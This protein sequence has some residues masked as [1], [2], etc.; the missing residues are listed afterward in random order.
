MIKKWTFIVFQLI[1]AVLSVLLSVGLLSA[2]VSTSNYSADMIEGVIEDLISTSGTPD[3]EIIGQGSYI[4]KSGFRDPLLGGSS[5][6][7]MR[8][9]LKNANV[10]PEEAARRWVDVQNRIR[11]TVQNKFG[12]MTFIVNGKPVNA[13]QAILQKI[14][15]YPPQQMMKGVASKAEAFALFKKYGVVPN[16]GYGAGSVTDDILEEAAEGIWGSGAVIQEMEKGARGK[17]WFTDGTTNKDGTK[18]VLTG[19]PGEIHAEEGIGGITAQERANVAKQVA[20]K[21]SNALGSDPD[22]V[23]KNLTRLQRYL[24]QAKILAGVKPSANDAM[25][26]SLVK[27]LEKLEG[28]ALEK[29]IA[30]KAGAIERALLDAWTDSHLLEQI[31]TKPGALNRALYG[32]MLESSG[33]W[34]SVRGLLNDAE[35]KA[36]AKRQAFMAAIVLVWEAPE[37]Y[38]KASKEGLTSAA[39]YAT[40]TLIA[41][42]MP[43]A[44]HLI[45][46]AAM[47]IA[48]QMVDYVAGYGYD[49]I[50]QTQDCRDLLAGLY[51]V[52]G[53]EAQVLKENLPRPSTEVQDLRAYYCQNA[54]FSDAQMSANLSTLVQAHAENACTR[55]EDYKASTDANAAVALFNKC[56]PMLQRLLMLEKQS[57]AYEARSL[58]QQLKGLEV[59]PY[60]DKSEA[61]L[62]KGK[63]TVRV[64]APFTTDPGT[65]ETDLTAIL[66]C[67]DRGDKNPGVYYSYK[68][69]AGPAQAGDKPLETTNGKRNARSY[70]FDKAGTQKVCVALETSITGISSELFLELDD[71]SV[72]RNPVCIDVEIREGGDELPGDKDDSKDDKTGDDKPGVGDQKDGK[73]GDGK[74]GDGDKKE[75]AADDKKDGQKSSPQVQPD[76]YTKPWEQAGIQGG[77]SGQAG[78][79]SGVS[80]QAG[81]TQQDPT[82]TTQT[83]GTATGGTQGTTGTTGVST[84][85]GTGKDTPVGSQTGI[86]SGVGAGIGIDKGTG[87]TVTT[88]PKEP[89]VCTYE[90][91]AW[92]ECSRATKTRTRTVT[93][94]K[95]AGCVEKGKPVLEEGCQP[96]PTEEEKRIAY[97]N[98]LCGACGGTGGGYYNP[99]GWGKPCSCFGMLNAWPTGLNTDPK[100]VADC[101]K[102]VYGKP[103]TPGD[104]DKAVKG[105]KNENRK[106]QTPLKL[107]LTPEKCPVEAQLGDIITFSAGVEGGA[108]SN[109]VSWSGDG[110]AK[111]RT[112]TFANSRTP[113]VHPI[114]VTVTDEDGTSVTKSCSVRV[115]AF[116]VTLKV[117]PAKK[118]YLI[119][120]TVT[121]SAEVKAGDAPARGSFVFR[122]QP[123]PEV[124]FGDK[125]ET[126]GSSTSGK[127]T[128]IGPVK[129][130]VNLLQKEGEVLRTVGESDQIEAEVVKP[131]F[132]LALTPVDPLVGQE[133]KAVVSA[134]PELDTSTIDFWWEYKGNVLNPGPLRDNREYTFKPRD[135]NPVTLTVHG[136]AKDGGADLGQKQ[137]T[138]T[139]KGYDV[140]IGEPRR[141]GPKPMIW[142]SP[143]WKQGSG[144]QGDFGLV[145]LADDQFA[146]FED[147]FVTGNVKPSPE[148]LPLRYDWSID[149]AGICGIPGAGQE[150]RLNCS[151]TGTYTVNLSARDSEN[152]VLGKASRPVSITVSKDDIEKGKS[153]RVTLQADKTTLKTGETVVIK[154]AAQGGKAP[155]AYRWSDGLDAKDDTARLTPKKSGTEKI[156]VEV[157]DKEGKKATANLSV[158]VER[159]KLEVT[160]KAAKTDIKL[161]ET[162]EI[163][164]EAKGGEAPLTYA[165]GPGLAGKG[166]SVPFVAKK[167]GPQTISVEVTDKARQKAKA[168]V[169]LKVEIPK[170]EVT[171]KADKTTLKVGETVSIQAAVKGGVPPVTSKWSAGTDAK[172]EAASF[173][174]KKSGSYKITVDV[175][176][177]AKQK[178]NAG[179][180]IKVE[181]AKLEISLKADKT[182]LKLGETAALQ[183][184]IK[185][186][187]PPL[188]YQ[189]GS[190]VEGK[191]DSGRFIADKPGTH[192]AS[193]EVSDQAGQKVSASV[194][195][196]VEVPKIEIALTPDKPT[197]KTGEKGTIQAKVKGGMPDYTYQ[198]NSLVSGKGETA[199]FTPNKTGTYKIWLEVRDKIGGKA[200]AS[201]DWKVEEGGG[202]QTPQVAGAEKI[203][204]EPENLKLAAGET[205]TLQV[206]RVLPDGRK[207][208]YTQGKVS[209]SGAPSQGVVVSD[210]GKVQ[211]NSLARPGARV[212]IEAQAGPLKAE[213][214]V[215]V[216]SSSKTGR[217]AIEPDPLQIAPGGTGELRLIAMAL[218]GK[219]ETVPTDRV[220]W[221]VER[222]AGVSIDSG[223]KVSV[224][225][226]V[227][228]GKRIKVTAK[229]DRDPVTGIIEVAGSSKTPSTIQSTGASTAATTVAPSTS[230]TVSS[231]SVTTAVSTTPG[232]GQTASPGALPPQVLV[233]DPA[234]L[235]ISPGGSA[236]FRVFTADVNGKR[237]DVTNKCTLTVRS[238]SGI[239]IDR[240]GLV[241]VAKTAK[242]GSIE[243]VLVTFDQTK[244]GTLRADGTIRIEGT[245]S[246]ASGGYDPLTDRGKALTVK[247]TDADKVTKIAGDFQKGQWTS[248]DQKDQKVKDQQTG[249]AQSPDYV[250][251]TSTASTSTGTSGSG[252]P[253]SQPTTSQPT[254]SQ[255]TTSQPTTTNV[256]VTSKDLTDVTVDRQDVTITVWDHGME[257]GDI[258]NI[259]LNGN[260]LKS[261]LLLTNKKQSFKVKLT[262]GQNRFEVE[263]VNEGSSPPNTATVEIS[264]VTKGKPSQVYERKSGQ[265]TSM[266]LNAP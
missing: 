208:P 136:K 189:W 231:T 143:E 248:L 83:T 170:L 202:G 24:K 182:T 43:L 66:R 32:G 133:V 98:C 131:G 145:E 150:L 75:P 224:G 52:Y 244:G 113:G 163:K 48:E 47:W 128:K 6:F 59:G 42:S 261:K 33:K 16:L 205:Q 87:Q 239:K 85:T 197:L 253:T 50:I 79:T 126:A 158:K 86:T 178:A 230:P 177:D 174:P 20:E 220:K 235:T 263:A 12:N 34:A 169:E 175:S 155:Y 1:S 157:T 2:A 8:L 114:S 124:D 19:S 193:L 129:F 146:V 198:W 115:N 62:A 61:V 223:G 247:T 245:R 181:P 3:M 70:N 109:T 90:Y 241:S 154:A 191:G 160:L 125:F 103:P 23:K 100:V 127:L 266:N 44:A 240:N 265:R 54:K 149:P 147:I 176:D 18:K 194:D 29:A 135:T 246:S 199:V 201:L 161:G 74:P 40:A 260:V 68:W 121:L 134:P 251:T 255:P 254:T 209:W 108:P 264:N 88:T 78:I 183:A 185:G 188:V 69:Y 237:T 119:G 37:L 77:T 51:T 186:G 137:A 95:P 229:A 27:E 187:E 180:D 28:E 138:V 35:F 168:T 94:K 200:T 46:M 112:F 257:D 55:Y 96:P 210:Q 214:W 4:K 14:N 117:E 99:S 105:A 162:V 53:R 165:W 167:G 120:S 218:D 142:K 26:D 111:D 72:S 110:Q 213:A 101:Y 123:H 60:Y 173:T 141:R 106:Y 221:E 215:E 228:M 118:K 71:T 31:A 179:I 107:T 219:K 211:A 204:I 232:G 206:L 21:T 76:S 102:S 217:Q 80:G 41:A 212:M 234:N 152:V 15:V 30:S 84:G 225:P 56:F 132:E 159:A 65:L 9:R 192:K 22:L 5:D 172:G 171:L 196:K 216:V 49:A 243:P 13:A 116:T 139:A 89:P 226:T 153:P 140:I 130:W 227:P 97:L 233:M 195:L 184:A 39:T 190:G 63:A 45:S 166:D 222:V 11:Q 258:I 238:D 249:Q 151:K 144:L 36:F 207:E 67:L 17:R 262:G 250:G 252:T 92:G 7:D 203:A 104:L 81:I 236:G 64:T 38:R 148:K 122:W 93:A 156:T 242:T 256:G 25:I 91:S 73:P 259:Y 164:A 82:T 10:S 58:I 57:A